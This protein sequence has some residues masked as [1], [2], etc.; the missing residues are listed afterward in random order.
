VSLINRVKNI[1]LSPATEWEVIAKEP[2]T[3]GGIMTGYVIPV[4]AAAA[5]VSLVS[6][7]MFSS[8]LAGIPGM[9]AAMGVSMVASI[10]MAVTSFLLQMALVFGMGYI[11]SA[12]IPSFGGQADATQ[13]LK[14]IAYAGTPVWV[15]TI[16]PIIGGFLAIVGLIYACYLIVI[17]TKPVLGVPEEKKAGAGVVILLV[18]FV[19][20]IIVGLI[21]AGINMAGMFATMGATGL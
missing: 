19:G 11:V 4:A 5:I 13:G 17:G 14:L 20:A 15:A 6:T 16:I 9:G 3:T 12:L 21:S 8:L 18:Y 1:L 2:A 10:I 7:L